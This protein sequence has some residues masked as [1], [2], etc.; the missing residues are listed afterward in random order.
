[1]SNLFKVGKA[2]EP[3]LHFSSLAHI[4][5]DRCLRKCGGIVSFISSYF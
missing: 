4:L 3:R 5:L 2:L 1:M